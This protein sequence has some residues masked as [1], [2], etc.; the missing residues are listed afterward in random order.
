[1]GGLV[2][3]GFFLALAASGVVLL[4]GVLAA[5][6]RLLPWWLSRD[7][8]LSVSMPF[9]LALLAAAMEAALLVGAPLGLALTVGMAVESGEVR[10]LEALGASP[11][12]IARSLWPVPAT[13]GLLAFGL[14]MAWDARSAP[15]GV[16]A[17]KLVEEAKTSCYNTAETRAI[18]V[19]LVNV[20]WMCFQG[21]APRV[22]APLPG[23][24]DA[25]VVAQSVV[26]SADLR[27][28]ALAKMRILSRPAKG[29][30]TLQVSVE[31][32]SI[33]GLPGWGRGTRLSGSQRGIVAAL[34]LFGVSIAG[35]WSVLRG[36]LHSLIGVVPVG[37]LPPALGLAVMSRLD[38]SDL[39]LSLFAVVPAVCA[40]LPVA[41]LWPAGRL[42]R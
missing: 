29:R 36:K 18:S 37:L 10:A 7:I 14:D 17:Q 5:S 13:L 30:P 27:S 40:L 20:T 19:P 3:R 11:R 41:L 2:R 33:R 22:V 4:L 25:W 38:A 1:M 31:S 21:Q 15:P 9:A 42:R 12:Q 26:F 16:F 34:L 39:P 8:P 24:G 35:A 6:V 28:I 23:G 32:G